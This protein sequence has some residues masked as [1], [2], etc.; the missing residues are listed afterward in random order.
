MI[1]TWFLYALIMFNNKIN[2]FYRKDTFPEY[3]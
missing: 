3:L 2:S 1:K